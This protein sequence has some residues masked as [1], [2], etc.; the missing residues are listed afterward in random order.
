ME[1]LYFLE[2]LRTPIV[3]KFMLLITQFG[4]ETAFL[5]LA[6]IIFWCVDK[7]KGYYILGIGF[8]GTILNQ[9]LKL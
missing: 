7:Y 9:F 4:E 1:F 5:V 6:L 2:K 8:I 3:D